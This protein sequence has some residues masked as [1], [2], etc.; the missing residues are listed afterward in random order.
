MSNSTINSATNDLNGF[1]SKPTK[2]TIKQIYNSTGVGMPQIN[3]YR[4]IENITEYDE[5]IFMCTTQ[6]NYE[7][8]G[9]DRSS[10]SFPVVIFTINNITINGSGRR[11][12]TFKLVDDNTIECINIEGDTI[13][14][15]AE[16]YG[17]K[18]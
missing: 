3:D 6:N 16:I 18:Y 4:T 17:V 1:D 2:Y 11:S 12:C 5:L 7:C 15:V 8:G 9:L 10:E 13:F 14:S